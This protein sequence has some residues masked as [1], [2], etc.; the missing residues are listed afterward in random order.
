MH[1]TSMVGSKRYRMVGLTG[2]VAVERPRGTAPFP[3]RGHKSSRIVQST[4][5]LSHP[6]SGGSCVRSKTR[7]R[8]IN[9]VEGGTAWVTTQPARSLPHPR[10]R[11][12]PR[13]RRRRR[14]PLQH[15]GR[16]LALHRH[17]Q[18]QQRRCL[19]R[20]F[21]WHQ[22]SLPWAARASNRHHPRPCRVKTWT[23][24]SGYAT[25]TCT[26]STGNRLCCAT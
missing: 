3:H 25:F 22:R 20:P 13:R 8:S 10:S 26:A 4:Q 19:H 16:S 6:H 9:A 23:T 18:R 11:R 1:G 24:S 15:R 12:V 17:P 7:A 21:P 5:W 14:R 2:L